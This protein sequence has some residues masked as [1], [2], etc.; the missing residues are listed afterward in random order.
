MN[1]YGIIMICI[2]SR[3]LLPKRIDFIFNHS[4]K[5]A[6]R[7]A[8]AYRQMRG[9]FGIRSPIGGSFAEL[10]NSLSLLSVLRLSVSN[11]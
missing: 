11:R 6:K 5:Q 9:G 10:T 7:K 4:R 8:A 2:A 3:T 1:A